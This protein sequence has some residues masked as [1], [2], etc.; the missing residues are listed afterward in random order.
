MSNSNS[1]F[2]A[3]M[4][5]FQKNDAPC[6][7]PT[8]E[9]SCEGVWPNITKRNMVSVILAHTLHIL[10]LYKTFFLGCPY[11]SDTE[12]WHTAQPI[13]EFSSKIDM[14]YLFQIIDCGIDPGQNEC[15]YVAHPNARRKHCGMHCHCLY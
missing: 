7:K 5:N 9:R 14:K 1:F 2:H 4:R 13:S 15:P 10:I 8:K 12:P 3:F 11:N 6:V